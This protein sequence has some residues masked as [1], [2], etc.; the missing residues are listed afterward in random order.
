MADLDEIAKRVFLQTLRA[1]EPA[2]VIK[3]EL[4]VDNDI[5]ILGGR[6]IPL[7]AY[8]E[9]VLIGL[10][11]ASVT[12]GAA[13]E[14]V[15]GNRVKRGILVTDR[16]PRLAVRSEVVVAGHPLPD[17]KSLAAGQRIVDIIE[18]C[19]DRS[20]IVF[21]ISG[22]GSSLVELPLSADISLE[23]LR[24]TNK[25]LIGCGA[26]IRE[27]NSVRKHLSRIKGGRLGYLARKSQC[28]ALYFSDVNAGDIRSIASNPLLPDDS[29]PEEFSNVVKKFN[30][31]E[32][33]PRSVVEAI[34]RSEAVGL[35][36][37]WHAS[38]PVTLLLLDNSKAVQTAAELARQHGFRVEVDAQLIEGDYE[39]VAEQSIDRLLKFKSSFPGERVCVISG[40]EVSCPVHAAGIGGRNQEFVLYSAALLV[41]SG[42]R[43]GAAV[44]SCG[45]DG[46]DG[47][48]KA[49]GA[50]ASPQ[51]V[52]KAARGCEDAISFISNNDSNSFFKKTGGLI[53]TGPT[54]NN[55][56][57][58]RILMAQ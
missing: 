43:E 19:T 37:N 58:L 54:G 2:S 14:S 21:L 53:V 7:D 56:R 28:I 12:M 57:D 52:I 10:G 11:K 35:S 15:F 18:S 29:S 33:L 24:F 27:I 36:R 51:S 48:S 39:R 8:Q 31:M 45:T 47:N 3:R 34:G 9:V 41:G 30:L 20:L 6:E 17:S 44:L 13:V 40:S 1:I 49:A 32:K 46:I 25:V 23:D 38:E 22:G 26:S 42:I 55:V 50:V 4:K 5:L 16:R